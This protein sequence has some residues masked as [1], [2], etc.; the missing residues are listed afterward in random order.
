MIALSISN[1]FT[2]RMLFTIFATCFAFLLI[3][4]GHQPVLADSVGPSFS[5]IYPT[6]G[7]TVN[8]TNVVVAIIAQDA[9]LVEYS[10]LIMKV[11]NVAVKPIAQY[12]PIDESTD[13]YSILEIYYPATF[14]PGI[15]TVDVTVKDKLNNTGNMHW[16]F[17]VTNPPKVLSLSPANGATV[18]TRLPEIVAT[19]TSG[20]SVNPSSIRMTLN[21][22]PV[23]AVFNQ[24][25]GT[26][27]YTPTTPLS[28]ETFYNVALS[29]K[30]VSGRT[31]NA[32]WQFYI[33]TFQEMTYSADDSTCQRCHDRTQHTM[34]NCSGCHGVNLSATVPTYPLDDC[35]FCHIGTQNYPSPYHSNGLPLPNP[36][37]HTVQ[38]TYS[39]IECHDKTWVSTV[40]PSIHNVFD[41]AVDH[42]TTTTGCT[43]CHSSSLTRE[44][45]RRTDENGSA[46][47]CFTCHSSPDIN[48]KSA[49]LLKDSSCTACHLTS[50]PEHNSGLDAACQTCHSSTLLA[51]P[52]YH[53]QNDCAICHDNTSNPLVAYSISIGN[54]NC[55]S[56][57]NQGH[58]IKFVEKT[59]ADIPLYSGFAWSQPQAVAPW[60]DESWFPAEFKSAGAKLLISN[61][62]TD[63][64]GTD[65]FDWYSQSLSDNGW[66]KTSGPEQGS[67]YFTLIYQKGIR[68]LY[69]NVYAGAVHDPT[70]PFIG[71]RVEILYK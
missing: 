35:Y 39:C 50:H 8:Q 22:T 55:F 10:S 6:N 16:S 52:Q 20:E 25:Y 4:L 28:N 7:Q 1:R 49:I 63:I 3:T 54:S 32:T 26:I 15:H 43:D 53:S 24:V 64:T 68:K 57:H 58:N 47:T 67:D 70:A 2:Q 12:G 18:I 29:L 46:L 51:E 37:E 45:L 59:P 42:T 21:N 48:V 41:T 9:D 66:Q 31:V 13:D 11:D 69:I 65:L 34:T 71:H 61:H 33:N 27:S 60:S 38:I 30:D 36:P 56:C 23:N 62:R 19:V 44:H 40:I 14:T 5:Q 17:T